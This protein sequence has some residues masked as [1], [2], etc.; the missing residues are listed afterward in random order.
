MILRLQCVC[1]RNLADVTRPAMDGSATNPS[2]TPDGLMVHARPN[3]EMQDYRPWPADPEADWKAHTY[4]FRCRCVTP[5]RKRRRITLRHER[6]SRMWCE[7]SQSDQQIVY[8]TI[9]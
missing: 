2:W 1:G 9:E 5:N 8:L 4:T 7:E 3:V 6:V